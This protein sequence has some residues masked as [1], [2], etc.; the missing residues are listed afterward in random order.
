MFKSQ[1]NDAKPTRKQF[2]I[3]VFVRQFHI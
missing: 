3:M 2:P 1:K